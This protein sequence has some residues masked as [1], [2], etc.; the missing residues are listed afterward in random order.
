MSGEAVVALEVAEADFER[1]VEAWDIDAETSTMEEEDRDEFAKLKRRFV[2]A[3]SAG[4]I[5]ISDVGDPTVSLRYSAFESITELSFKV[6]GG[7]AL[8]ALDKYKEKQ[9]VHK[10]HAYIGGMTGE[11]PAIFGKMDGRDI[12]VCQ[13]IAQLFLGS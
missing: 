4:A 6:P 2:N 13:A 10:L 9:G 11:S 3:V 8:L 7:A 1:F 5:T 12:K